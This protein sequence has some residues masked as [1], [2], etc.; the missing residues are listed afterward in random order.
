MKLTKKIIFVIVSTAVIVGS[1]YASW[2]YTHSGS[3]MKQ[4]RYLVVKHSVGSNHGLA[5]LDAKTGMLVVADT[6]YNVVD[7]DG[8]LSIFV[9]D[10]DHTKKY[11]VV[12]NNGNIIIK[13]D[14]KELHFKDGFI[15]GDNK[16]FSKSGKKLFDGFFY[17]QLGFQNGVAIVIDNNKKMNLINKDGKIIKTFND[18]IEDAVK[19]SEKYYAVS[20]KRTSTSDEAN[21]YVDYD[22][23]VWGVVDTKGDTILSFSYDCIDTFSDGLFLVNK[24]GRRCDYGACADSCVG[25]KSGYADKTGKLVIPYTYSFAYPFHNGTAQVEID[26]E[27]GEFNRKYGF[28]DTKGRY[29]VEP[30]IKSP[31]NVYNGIKMAPY[32]AGA[33]CGYINAEGKKLTE[34]IYDSCDESHDGMASVTFNG[35]CGYVNEKGSMVVQA[36]YDSCRSFKEELAPVR[37][38]NKCGYINKKG[39]IIVNPTYD[40]CEEFNSGAAVIGV[41]KD[42][43]TGSD[44]LYDNSIYGAINTS[45]KIIAAI[46]F[47]QISKFDNGT[48]LT[49]LRGNYG[50]IHSKNKYEIS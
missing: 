31:V 16:I 39:T 17:H 6:K 4:S 10:V 46:Q 18:I 41:K 26:G 28:I 22:N 27:E 12:D 7:Y 2:S 21:K 48:A 14:I 45:G 1:C 23:V 15:V 32:S 34:P 43:I 36:V 13:P 49:M 50:V 25:G 3:Q 38:N 8:K 19:I 9:I 11:G 37:M 24:G 47:D 44:G 33:R 29:V 5:I 35:K 30:F 20:V 40:S 42:N